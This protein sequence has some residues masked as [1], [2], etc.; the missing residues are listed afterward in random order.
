MAARLDELVAVNER[1]RS[2]GRFRPKTRSD[3]PF[4]DDRA[5]Q[6]LIETSRVAVFQPE[7]VSISTRHT[8][9][10]AGAGHG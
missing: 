6:P 4:H 3:Q 1:D 9:I 7:R 5:P 2:P 8:G 10:F